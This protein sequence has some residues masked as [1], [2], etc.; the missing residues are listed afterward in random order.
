MKVTLKMIAEKAKVSQMTVSRILNRKDAGQVSPEV[1]ARV[2]AIAAKMNY[3]PN[4]AA[5]ALRTGAGFVPGAKPVIT[6]LLPCPEYL[7]TQDEDVEQIMRFFNDIIQAAS[8]LGVRVETLPVSRKN[9][10]LAP[11]WEWLN[12]LDSNSRVVAFTTWFMPVLVILAQQGCRIAHVSGEVFW[13]NI[14]ERYTRDW[15]LFTVMTFDGT[16]Q[17]VRHLLDSGSTQIA[18]ASE[19]MGEPNDPLAMGYEQ[20]LESFGNSYRH[21][22]RLQMDTNESETVYLEQLQAAYKDSPFDALILSLPSTIQLKY[23]KSLNHAL[24]LP[25]EIKIVCTVDR[26]V[27]AHLEPPVTAFEYPLKK[28]AGD[29][30]KFLLDDNPIPGEQFYKGNLIKRD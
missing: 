26:E 10:P 21:F 20:E 22:I 19:Y 2:R 15:G 24:K 17:A 9:N 18:L 28:I 14:Y 11:E 29:V 27:F 5:R 1:A 12:S 7:Q 4:N 25:E 13:R 3:R 6:F 8:K 23:S 30:V 16:C